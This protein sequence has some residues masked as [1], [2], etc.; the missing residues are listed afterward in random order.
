MVG[1]SRLMEADESGTLARLKAHR[2]ELIDPTIDQYN[3]RIIKTTG[4]GMLVEFAS[5]VDA[6][7][8]AA[9]IQ[10][11]MARRNAEMP[12]DRRIDFRIGVNLGD[13]IVEDDDVFGDGV[14]IA[15]RL[16]TLAEPGGICL[17]GTADDHL[18]TKIDLGYA[19]LG[20]QKLKNI[21]EPVRVYRV[22]LGT[23]APGARA[24]RSPAGRWRWVAAAAAMVVLVAGGGYWLQ[25]NWW[26][27][28]SVEAASLENMAFPLPEKPSIAVLPFD[29]LTGDAQQEIFVDGLSEEIIS[30]L[31]QVPNLFVI[32]RNSTFT[33]KGKAVRASQV[34]EKLGVRYV[35]EGSVRQAGDDLRITTQLVD[36]LQGRNKWSRSYDRNNSN[37]L[38]LQKDIAWALAV[39]LEVNLTRGEQ[40]RLQKATTTNPEAYRLLLQSKQHQGANKENVAI[41]LGSVDNHLSARLGAGQMYHG[42]E[43]VVGFVVACGDA[44]ELLEIAEEILDQMA[45]L[46]HGEV[47][48]DVTRPVGLGR[49]D[50]DG[51]SVVQLGADPVDVEGLVGKQGVEV[52]V[53]DQRRDADAVVTLTRQQDEARQSA[54]RIDQRHDLGRQ[55]AARSADGLIL[56]PPLA[57][58]PCWWT[59]TIVPSII[60]YSKSGSSDKELKRLSKT[61]FCA[62]R[63]KRR[64][65]EF[66]GPNRA[67][68]SRHGAPVRAIH[69]IASRTRR[70]SAPV[71]PGSPGLPGRSGASRAHCASLKIS[72]SK[73]DLHFSALNHISPIKGIPR[74]LLNVHRPY[75]SLP[76]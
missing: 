34:A 58:A 22:E 73:A 16:E 63:R 61:P 72:R 6:V 4:D 75:N 23:G 35:L 36:A 49:D 59:R 76:K 10:S 28:E 15:A 7:Q 25:D 19:D 21:S 47:A 26:R 1:F 32:D 20:E 52:D 51:A 41:R 37:V 71:R 11:R 14:N 2:T 57:P 39:A 38:N 69:N 56:S 68:R 43:A 24:A 18:K 8:C 65:T 46:V 31:S 29:N 33:Y 5:V 45:P 9:E 60:T 50:G 12:D 74:D 53:G 55:P 66:Q 64:N 67:C 30:T 40:A 42:G 54:E 17:S 27:F 62:Q 44:T 48:G 70:L 13:I 3:G